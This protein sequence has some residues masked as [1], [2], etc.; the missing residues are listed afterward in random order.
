[1]FSEAGAPRLI[2]RPGYLAVHSVEKSFGTRQVVRGVSIYVRRGEAVGLLGPNGAGKTTLLEAIAGLIR[3]QVFVALVVM[4]LGTS[5]LSGPS[6]SL[7]TTPS[8]ASTQYGVPPVAS[9]A[10]AATYA[11]GTTRFRMFT[12]ASAD[13]S[14]VYV[15]ICDAGTIADIRTNT[16]SIGA[17]SNYPDQLITDIVAPSGACTGLCAVP[18]MITGFSISSGVV[19][20]QAT[21]TFTP[22]IGIG[23]PCCMGGRGGAGK[24]DFV[25]TGMR[26][27]IGAD[28]AIRRDPVEN[29]RR[30]LRFRGRF[31]ENVAVQDRPGRRLDDHRVPS[32]ERGRSHAN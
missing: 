21:N 5:L 26:N 8:F 17:G 25:D 9:C 15:S 23:A 2:K 11:P 10:P 16:I 27:Q 24:G 14:H 13:S 1:M 31:G 7:L 20:F 6:M 30:H 3:E 22:G 32:D 19:T 12:T 18:A 4:A 29:P 28:G